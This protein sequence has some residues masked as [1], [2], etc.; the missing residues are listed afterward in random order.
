MKNEPLIMRAPR[1]LPSACMGCRHYRGA[2]KIDL[3]RDI[4]AVICAAFP[5]GIP[6]IVVDNLHDHKAPIPD[7]NGIQ[8]E[9]GLPDEWRPKRAR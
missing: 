6:D 4:D 7:D 5:D 9:K 2:I 3:L 8:F 1:M